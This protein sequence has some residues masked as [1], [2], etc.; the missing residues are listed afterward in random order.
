MREVINI[1]GKIRQILYLQKDRESHGLKYE[2]DNIIML[3]V[4]KWR[5]SIR[6]V[7]VIG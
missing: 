1:D 5:I 6:A 4:C 2:A 7:V 3:K